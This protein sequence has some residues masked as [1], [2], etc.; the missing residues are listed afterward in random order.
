MPACP[1]CA[2]LEERE[3][4]VAE[5]ALA[6]LIADAFPLNPGHHLVVPR[7]HEGDYFALSPEEAAALWELA[8]EAR[9]II[10]AERHPDG[11]NLGVN[12]GEAGGQTIGHVHVHVIPRYA[13][14]V[15]DPRGGIRW[16]VPERAAY[17][18]A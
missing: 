17:W 7:R 9:R 4:A 3:A 1:L 16:I 11:Y 5:N 12:V 15:A 10:D 6:V 2:V 14:D 13:G 18:E 8:A